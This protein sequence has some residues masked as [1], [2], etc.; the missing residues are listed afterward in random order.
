MNAAKS[1]KFGERLCKTN[2]DN[3]FDL[4]VMPKVPAGD[5]RNEPLVAVEDLLKRK[6]VAVEHKFDKLVIG[7]FNTNG[8]TRSF[9][10]SSLY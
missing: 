6:M 3:F 4:V 1:A 2:L 8:R 10:F 7:P 9:S 5:D